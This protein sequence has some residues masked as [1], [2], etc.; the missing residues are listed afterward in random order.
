MRHLNWIFFDDDAKFDTEFAALLTAL[1]E[2]QPHIKAH[3]RYQ[4]DALEWERSSRNPS[5]LMSGDNLAFAE[6]WLAQS[7]S[8]DPAPTVIQREYIAESRRVEDELK[9]Q[10][11]ERERRIRRFRWAS[12]VLAVIGAL[13]V[14]ASGIAFGQAVSSGNQAATATIAQGQALFAQATSTAIAG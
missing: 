11:A 10:A 8:K 14:I 2:D 7:T 12:T 9:R 3:T 1:E 4:S 5:F 6:T 13:A